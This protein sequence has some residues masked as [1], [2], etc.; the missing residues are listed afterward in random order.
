MQTARQL[1]DRVIEKPKHSVLMTKE[2]VNA[3][4]GLGAHAVSY[5]FDQVVN[6]SGT[7]PRPW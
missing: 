7:K 6:H 5:D 2:A 3:Y 4:A 1:A